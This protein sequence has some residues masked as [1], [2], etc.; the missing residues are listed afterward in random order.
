MKDVYTK[1]R[2][3]WI[4]SI[5]RGRSKALTLMLYIA[6]ASMLV[7][8]TSPAIAHGEQAMCTRNATGG[9]MILTFRHPILLMDGTIGY[10]A[11][12]NEGDNTDNPVKGVWKVLDRNAI[13]VLWYLDDHTT[14]QRKYPPELF[15]R[16]PD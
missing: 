7:F 6:A 10:L 15:K 16:C 2:K 4:G 13:G 3:R 12:S 14:E 8:A 5:G 9:L 11:I 1:E